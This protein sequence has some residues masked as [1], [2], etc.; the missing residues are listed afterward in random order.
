ML[1]HSG[2]AERPWALNMQGICLMQQRRVEEAIECFARAADAGPQLP[3]IHQNWANALD[4]MGCFDEARVRRVRALELPGRTAN[5]I[6]GKAINASL[7][8]RHDQ[9]LALARRALALAP[10]NARSWSAWGY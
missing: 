6:A 8:H 4:L 1:Q 3:F 5:L 2:A 9:A 7:L 10:A